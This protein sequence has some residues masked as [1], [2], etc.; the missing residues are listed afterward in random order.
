[1]ISYTVSFVS[2]QTIRIYPMNQQDTAI[3]SYGSSWK[4]SVDGG[5]GGG[6]IRSH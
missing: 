2:L 6:K 3:T 5:V 4:S 1:M